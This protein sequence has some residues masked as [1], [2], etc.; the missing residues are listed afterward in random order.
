M[1]FKLSEEQ[2]MIIKTTRDFVVTNSIPTKPRLRI[3]VLRPSSREI[4]EGHCRGLYAA[5]MP[6]EAGGAGPRYL[7]GF[8]KGIGPRQLCAPLE[9][10]GAVHILM[11]CVG[12]QREKYLYPAVAGKMVDCLAMTEPGVGSD[13]RGMKCFAKADGDDFIINGTKHFISHADEAT[14]TILFAATGEEDTPRG[15]KKLITAFLVDK[16]TKGFT[17]RDGYKNVSH[18]GYNKCILEFNDCRLH[19]SQIL[20]ELHK[21]LMSPTNG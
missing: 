14:F 11:A 13:V 18:R 15:K 6:A 12:E 7:T 3:R 4:K 8:T 5:N 16:G 10:R 21:G 2:D 19:K 17:V 1:D 9:L 20:G